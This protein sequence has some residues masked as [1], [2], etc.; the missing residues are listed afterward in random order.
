MSFYICKKHK[1][2]SDSMKCYL[3]LILTMLIIISTGC[4]KKEAI[5][6]E[7]AIYTSS[8]K[9]EDLTDIPFPEIVFVEGTESRYAGGNSKEYKLF[10]SS[11]KGKEKLVEDIKKEVGSRLT[12]WSQSDTTYSFF[13]H[14]TH[15]D[16]RNEG[17]GNTTFMVEITIPKSSN[18]TI[19]VKE[20]MMNNTPKKMME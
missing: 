9:L 1:Y 7:D 14:N 19:Y 17:M 2:F 8:T 13:R 20:R 5:N 15:H 10:I 4:V 18:D 3:F 16:V 12:K 11:S 6:E